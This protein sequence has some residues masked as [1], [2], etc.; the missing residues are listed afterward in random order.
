MLLLV[1]TL[2]CCTAA[3]GR[4]LEAIADSVESL[5]GWPDELPSEHFS[6]YLSVRARGQW[7]TASS[8][9][10]ERLANTGVAH[11]GCCHLLL[12][13]LPDRA[14]CTAHETAGADLVRLVRHYRVNCLLFENSLIE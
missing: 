14:V 6:G 9:A 2:A 11:A 4:T 5:P 12:G 8:A 10:L 1:L 3:R 13:H 7:Q